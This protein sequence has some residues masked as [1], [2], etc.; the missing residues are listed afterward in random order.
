MGRDFKVVLAGGGTGGHIYPALAIAQ[1]LKEM[2]PAVQFLYIGTEDGLEA[3][4]VP[5]ASIP[6]K[7][8]KAGGAVGKSPVQAL[9]GLAATAA[10]VRRARALMKEFQPHAVVGTGGYAALP[11]G[12][13]AA[14]GRVPLIIHEQ[15]AVPSVTNRI[16]SRWSRVAGVP[17]ADTEKAL[18]RARR[19]EVTG[20]P[21]RREVLTADRDEA[22]R[23]LGLERFR[24]VVLVTSGS[25]G[26][27]T[28]NDATVELARRL[29]DGAALILITGDLYYDK[30]TARLEGALGGTPGGGSAADH[31]FRRWRGGA[32]M[33]SPY[34]DQM[35]L[36][37]AAADMVVCRAGGLTLAE[38]TAR[39]LPAVIVPS[40]NVTHNH[41][42]RNA[43]VLARGGAAAV[44]AD[45]ACTGDRLSEEVFHL[46]SH[47]EKRRQMGAAALELARPGAADH[48]AR[49][50][51][52]A[53]EGGKHHAR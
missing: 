2:R 50:V 8:I 3:E 43:A 9:R 42:E 7:G 52:Q 48:L 22:R 39:G 40:P 44:I 27:R 24:H 6:F 20:N 12:L 49:L 26:A 13:A 1:A 36:A 23:R 51:I 18:P 17:F 38:V 10:G 11:V 14:L 37:L 21:I 25:R 45:E 31:P 5:R 34:Y 19:L 28:I 47:R 35:E 16:L 53:G 32:V 15:N 30:V 41:Q 29:P 33:V 46:L 4:L